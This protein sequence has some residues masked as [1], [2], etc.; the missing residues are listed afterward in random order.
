[1][2][3]DEG[4]LIGDVLQDYLKKRASLRRRVRQ[5]S[6]IAEWAELVGPQLARV[7]KPEV[8]DQEGTL[9]V[10]V[11]SAPWIQELQLMSPTILKELGQRGKP[12]K[13][14]RWVGGMRG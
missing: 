3:R 14:I 5:A 7:T 1:M 11:T 2:R 8:V 9:W 13:R 12:V 4:G 6:V 10:R